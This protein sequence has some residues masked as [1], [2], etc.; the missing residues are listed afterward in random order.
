M[1]E[2][3]F[4]VGQTVAFDS[5]YASQ[6]GGFFKKHYH[7]I[8]SLHLHDYDPGRR[9]YKFVGEDTRCS[10]EDHLIATEGPW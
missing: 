3:K 7:V 9:V 2:S 4:H 8:D 1:V 5:W 6:F 10:Y